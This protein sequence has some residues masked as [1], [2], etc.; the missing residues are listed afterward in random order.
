[1]MLTESVKTGA[2][3]RFEAAQR[4]H[5]LRKCRDM[6]EEAASRYASIRASLRR[7]ELSGSRLD[8][9]KTLRGQSPARIGAGKLGVCDG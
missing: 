6:S 9:S 2:D 5:I 7:A 3:M 1:M 4:S 8:R